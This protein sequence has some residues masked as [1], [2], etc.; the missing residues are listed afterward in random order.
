MEILE[1]FKS[2]LYTLLNSEDF[3]RKAFNNARN[4]YI[5]SINNNEYK[6]KQLENLEI[7]KNDNFNHK[8]EIVNYYKDFN[9]IKHLKNL[10]QETYIEEETIIDLL[11]TKE[12]K[13][14]V[15]E[16]LEDNNQ[17]LTQ[18]YLLFIIN[19]DT[20]LD[21]LIKSAYVSLGRNK[22]EYLHL[23]KNNSIN[24]LQELKGAFSFIPNNKDIALYI[25]DDLFVKLVDRANNFRYFQTKANKYKYPSKVYLY[26]DDKLDNLIN[27]GKLNS[28]DV[29]ALSNIIETFYKKEN[30][31][32]LWQLYT[33]LNCKKASTG[34]SST[35]KEIT[36]D[37]LNKL[38]DLYLIELKEYKDQVFK[39]VGVNIKPNEVFIIDRKDV[40][41]GKNRQIITI[42]FLSKCEE[43]KKTKHNQYIDLKV[44]YKMLNHTKSNKLYNDKAIIEDL[45]KKYG[46]KYNFDTNF[47]I[48]NEEN[49]RDYKPKTNNILLGYWLKPLNN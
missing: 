1:K 38:V 10:I 46:K 45:I 4:Y 32:S 27:E 24:D 2:N 36:I 44:I 5:N 41:G 16:L 26:S 40:I 6:L 22:E 28:Y 14:A 49:I 48:N 13:N 3:I 19:F 25:I 42:Y 47:V 20:I 21:T 12:Y 31:F 18:D 35:K 11:E 15:N 34:K 29:L 43:L 8:E 17:E 30:K 39:V 7:I 33:L 9:V 37:T 23:L